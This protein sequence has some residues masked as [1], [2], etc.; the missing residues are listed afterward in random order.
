MAIAS[1]MPYLLD[2]GASERSY[3]KLT[4]SD[5]DRIRDITLPILNDIF[6]HA[7][8]AG[9]YRDRLLLLALCQGGAQHYVDGC[10][11]LKDIDV[12]AFFRSGPPK[13]FPCRTIWHADFRPSHHGRSPHDQGY[14]GRRIDIIGRSIACRE[15]ETPEQALRTW[16]SGGSTSAFFIAKRPVIGLAPAGYSGRLLWEPCISVPRRRPGQDPGHVHD[17]R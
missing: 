10:N 15:D 11:G 17:D 12:W 1:A 3:E 13:P 6:A 2:C 8:V 4:R 5:L 16:L 7:P 14:T 9:L